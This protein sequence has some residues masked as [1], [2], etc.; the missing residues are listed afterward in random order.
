MDKEVDKDKT[1]LWL[2]Y[3]YNE[4]SYSGKYGYYIKTGPKK[5]FGF[6]PLTT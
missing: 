1:V 2:A 4:N 3:L 6:E 5:V